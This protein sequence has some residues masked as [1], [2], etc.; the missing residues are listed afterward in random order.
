MLRKFNANPHLFLITNIK[1]HLVH[2]QLANTQQQRPLILILINGF[3]GGI[4]SSNQLI[5][6]VYKKI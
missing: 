1:T 5:N 6:F 4:S 2:A 3:V